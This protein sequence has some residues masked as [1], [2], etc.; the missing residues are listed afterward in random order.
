MDR[1]KAN[2]RMYRAMME[3]DDWSELEDNDIEP[4]IDQRVKVLEKVPYI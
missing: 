3:A 4:Y 2:L 1:M